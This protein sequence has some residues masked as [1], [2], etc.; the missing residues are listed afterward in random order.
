MLFNVKKNYQV[1]IVYDPKGA[2][3]NRHASIDLKMNI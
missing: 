3:T 2:K 1:N